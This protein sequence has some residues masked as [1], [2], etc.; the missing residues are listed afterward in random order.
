VLDFGTASHVSTAVCLQSG[1]F[2]LVFGAAR[3]AGILPPEGEPGPRVT[4]IGFGLVLGEDGKRFRTRSSE[5]PS[6]HTVAGMLALMVISLLW[7]QWLS[8]LLAHD[9]ILTTTHKCF[10][11]D[12]RSLSQLSKSA[13]LQR[14]PRERRLQCT[15]VADCIICA[16][17]L[18]RLVDLLDEAVARCKA[19]IKTRRE[20]RNE[21]ISDEV[22]G[23]TSQH[24]LCRRLLWPWRAVEC[25]RR[26]SPS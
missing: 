3:K 5:V 15:Q 9:H 19:T 4:H 2:R 10:C 18:V 16:M 14:Q 20:E 21:P 23:R 13:T 22:S 12:T 6:P 8:A 7:L 17:Q 11:Y 26:S 25:H 24:V 1:H